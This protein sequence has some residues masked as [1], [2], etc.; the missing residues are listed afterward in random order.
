MSDDQ[1]AKPVLTARA[2]RE[3]A[4]RRLRQALALRT[5]LLRRKAQVRARDDAGDDPAD[6]AG[7]L[8]NKDDSINRGGA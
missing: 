3:A 5:N 1:P 6:P 2:R 7:A 8:E 4:D